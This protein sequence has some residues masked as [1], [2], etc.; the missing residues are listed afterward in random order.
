MGGNL[1]DRLFTGL[2]ESSRGQVVKT[3]QYMFLYD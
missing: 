3:A 2:V 1:L